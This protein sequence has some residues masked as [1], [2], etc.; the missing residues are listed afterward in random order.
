M[1]GIFTGKPGNNKPK[2]IEMKKNKT[3]VFALLAVIVLLVMAV[4]TKHSYFSFISFT[5]KA[6][7]NNT[8]L[9]QWETTGDNTL[10][11]E[12]ERS[13][14][15]KEWKSLVKIS[16]VLDNRYSYADASPEE[17]YNYYRVKDTQKGNQTIYSS[18]NVIRV[19]RKIKI[20]IWPNPAN[21][22]LNVQTT[23]NTGNIDIVDA[24]GKIILKKTITSYITTLPTEKLN[25]GVFYIHIVH[26][27]D[28]YTEQFIKM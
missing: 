13:A 22:Q 23:F 27:E 17:G 19:N 24:S 2:I 10:Q 16:P 28:K 8:V 4:N 11:F 3:F 6:G 15:N 9:L 18:T 12:I 26:G 20:F 21:N 25:T 14:D 5:V 1:P 7:N